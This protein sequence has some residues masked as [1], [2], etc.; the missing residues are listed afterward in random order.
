M[1]MNKNGGIVYSLVGGGH[2]GKN[3]VMG[4]ES[5]NDGTEREKKGFHQLFQES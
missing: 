4:Q 1:L 2:G 3:G 5:S